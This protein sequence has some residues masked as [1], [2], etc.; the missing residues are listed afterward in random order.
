[1]FKI[2]NLILLFTIGLVLTYLPSLIFS[3]WRYNK[4]LGVIFILAI[5]NFLNIRNSKIIEPF[6]IILENPK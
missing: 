6:L 2:R 3:G 4:Y 5:Y 1:M